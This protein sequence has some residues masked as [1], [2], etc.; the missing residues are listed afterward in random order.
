VDRLLNSVGVDHTRVPLPVRERLRLDP[1]R[2]REWLEVAR[3]HGAAEAAVLSTCNRTEV[4]VS[5]D[6]G[7]WPV[8]RAW[9]AA[10]WSRRAAVDATR[11]EAL[12]VVRERGDA[13]R[14]LFRVC[15]GLES[16]LVGEGE[17]LA[18]VKDAYAVARAAGAVGPV[19]HP[20]FQAALRAGRQARRD[21][22]LGGVAQS[23]GAAV[24]ELARDA[25]DGDLAGRS[26]WVWGS[27]T[28]GRAA[29]EHLVEA[30]AV[31]RVASR[32]AANARAAAGERA[33]A[34]AWADREAAM[35]D[36]D[37]L[38]LAVSGAQA[39]LDAPE[40]AE[41][42]AGRPDRPLFV[43]DFGVPRNAH[44]GVAHVAGVRLVGVDDLG[45]HLAL[46]R[47]RLEAAAAEATALVDDAV[48]IFLREHRQ[49]RAA[50]LIRSLY[51]KAETVRRDELARTLRRLPDLPPQAR[52][53]LEHLTHRIVRRLL[54]DPALALRAGAAGAND[55][56]FFATAASLLGLVDETGDAGAG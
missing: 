15:A 22:A 20:L 18:Q 14:H 50:P 55:S 6:D 26:A 40:L 42:M 33:Q 13:V 11:L 10:D 7:A 16:V 32:T 19:L 1:A 23:P 12:W 28:I 21:T 54:N 49:R 41:A 27:G 36:A 37:V 51:E 43:V 5:C 9:M 8:L 44:P 31:V 25:L 38:V 35:V 45:A 52:E 4:V 47:A 34:V 39:W 53:A 30:G 56:E 48:A 17:I 24:V 29:V 3:M 2:A 46:G